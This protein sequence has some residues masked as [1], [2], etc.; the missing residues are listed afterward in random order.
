MM[1]NDSPAAGAAVR[2]ALSRLPGAMLTGLSVVSH[3]MQA[4]VQA[5]DAD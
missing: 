3:D 1:S 4:A 5:D 2:S